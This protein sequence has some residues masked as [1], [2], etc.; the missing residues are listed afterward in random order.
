M[1][2][3]TFSAA[4]GVFLS[5]FVLSAGAQTGKPAS[6]GDAAAMW[7]A[8]C[9]SCHM[10]YPPGLLP[11]RSWRKLMAEL[12]KH[13]GQNAS[14]DAAAT[15]AIVSYLV[16]NSAERGTSRRSAR[17]LGAIP[18]NATPLRITENAH[19]VREHREVSP[20]DWK[21][22]KVGSPANCNACHSDAEQGNFSE[23]NVKIPR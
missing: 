7:K 10:A 15:K 11:E 13:F 5:V 2:S 18:A 3:R 20:A 19:F 22:P 8:E 17:F 12:D 21:L 14:L 1:R 23:R 9:A 4:Y 6:S 16:E